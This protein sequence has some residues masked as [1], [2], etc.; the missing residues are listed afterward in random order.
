MA[1]VAGGGDRPQP[2][3]GDR[4]RV[5]LG[6]G[7]SVRP[8]DVRG[9]RDQAALEPSCPGLGDPGVV[10]VMVRHQYEIAPE[11][12]LGERPCHAGAMTGIVRTGIDHDGS[13]RARIGD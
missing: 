2:Q 3:A 10:R 7:G 1:A 6:D 11:V 9:R 12:A 8:G 5:A 4:D 13:A